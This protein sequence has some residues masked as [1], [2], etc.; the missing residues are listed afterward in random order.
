M[1]VKATA[2]RLSGDHLNNQGRGRYGELVDS[3]VIR[4]REQLC[5]F[6][7]H[8]PP[9]MRKKQHPLL[10]YFLVYHARAKVSKT[11]ERSFT[12][13]GGEPIFG[14]AIRDGTLVVSGSQDRTLRL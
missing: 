6:H 8:Y 9:H 13:S 3:Q 1:I 5:H 12:K 14:E 4:Q 7:Q 2:D 11:S 10:V